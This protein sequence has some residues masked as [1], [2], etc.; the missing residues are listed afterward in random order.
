VVSITVPSPDGIAIGDLTGDAILDVV[1]G[2]V[3]MVVLR[4]KG[5]GPFEAPET[6]SA[7]ALGDVGHVALGDFNR[8]SKL[9]VACIAGTQAWILFNARP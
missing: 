3:G 1:G 5:D 7:T 8:D 4:G 2:G 9:D 6:F